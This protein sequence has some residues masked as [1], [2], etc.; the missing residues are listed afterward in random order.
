MDHKGD[1]IITSDMHIKLVGMVT[2]WK[3]TWPKIFQME[4]KNLQTINGKE[5]KEQMMTKKIMTMKQTNNLLLQG[6]KGTGYDNQKPD[7]M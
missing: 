3:T 4:R 5:M 1:I 2:N 6:L 7:I